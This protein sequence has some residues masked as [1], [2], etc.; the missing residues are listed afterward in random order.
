[1]TKM[2][3]AA[4]RLVTLV[5]LSAALALFAVASSELVTFHIMRA[6]GG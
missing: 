6:F 2:Q 1:M 3:L 4:G 5:I